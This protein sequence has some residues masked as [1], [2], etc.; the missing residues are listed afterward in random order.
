MMYCPLSPSASSNG[1]EVAQ[2]PVS[3]TEWLVRGALV[4]PEGLWQHM[5][6]LPSEDIS[7]RWALRDRSNLITQKLL[8]FLQQE[9]FF[10]SG[11]QST[12]QSARTTSRAGASAKPLTAWCVAFVQLHLRVQLS[13]GP[14]LTLA[15][16]QLVLGE[17][18]AVACTGTC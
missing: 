18:S 10:A 8:T 9:A 17:C 4:L 2:N 13:Q 7:F 3:V 6:E 5:S 14:V 1:L 15:S 16:L 11:E 12:R